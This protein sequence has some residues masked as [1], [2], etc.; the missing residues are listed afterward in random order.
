MNRFT[1]LVFLLAWNTLVSGQDSMLL[2]PGLADTGISYKSS[3]Q[4]KPFYRDT[5]ANDSF[6]ARHF[7]HQ[8]SVFLP[9]EP[10]LDRL[11]EPVIRKHLSN[12]WRYSV[13]LSLMTFIGLVRLLSPGVIVMYFRSF[14]KP[15]LLEEVLEDQN[16]EISSISILI[17]LITSLMYA[18]P[19]QWIQWSLGR[20]MT[21]Y[22]FAD[23]LL[24]GLFIFF[25]I[26]ARFVL[27][28]IVGRIF[29]ARYYVATSIYTSVFLNFFLAALSIPAFLTLMLNQWVPD[30]NQTLWTV[31]ISIAFITLLKILR[32]LSQAADSFPYSRF[33]LILYLCALELGP[34]SWV[35]IL[36]EY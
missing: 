14:L 15:K 25:F 3:W 4:K 36:L 6:Q 20:E 7:F 18:L 31:F 35:Y 21:D 10:Y 12:T 24:I 19:A 11:G 30:L 32:S 29:E 28:S 27:A 2:S 9:M 5:L 22:P 34:W 26:V 33:Y 1:L 8:E 13:I 16:S 17:S 23:Y